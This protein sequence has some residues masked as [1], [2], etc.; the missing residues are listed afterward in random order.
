MRGK[1]FYYFFVPN[2]IR[3]TPAYAGKSQRFTTKE[4]KHE[5]HP[6]VCGEKALEKRS[7]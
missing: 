1:D 6:R 3:I 4:T 2:R 7:V 5:D